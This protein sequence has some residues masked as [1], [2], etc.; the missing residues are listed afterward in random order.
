MRRSPQRKVFADRKN[1][2]NVSSAHKLNGLGKI[3]EHA[4]RSGHVHL[5]LGNVFCDNCC[6]SI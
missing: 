5:H 3:K 1:G 4:P 2:K 6:C